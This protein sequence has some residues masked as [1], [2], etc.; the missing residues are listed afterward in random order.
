MPMHPAD[1]FEAFRELIDGGA[2]IVDVAARFSIAESARGKA[3][4][5]RQAQPRRSLRRT[6]RTISGLSRRRHSPCP[7]IMP[8]RKPCSRA[9]GQG[10]RS[11]RAIREALTEGEVPTSDRRVRFVGL[12]A[13]E[14]AGGAFGATC[15]TRRTA[16][17]CRTSG[18]LDR[19][20]LDELETVAAEASRRRLEVGR[21]PSRPAATTSWSRF[22]RVHAEQVPLCETDEAALEQLTGAIRRACRTGRS[23][24]GQC[25]ACRAARTA[26]CADRRDQRQWPCVCV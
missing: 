21:K 22:G 19:L 20:T 3:S 18:L 6:A 16:A 9:C 23:R 17:T 7:T 13:Y 15:S 4:A 25:G 10:G 5:A 1:Q 2:G 14:A 12:D 26:R 24:S 11:P 8:R